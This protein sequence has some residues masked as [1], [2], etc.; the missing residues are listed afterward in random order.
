MVPSP[1][2]RVVAGIDVGGTKK[3][4]QAV[5]LAEGQY[6]EHLASGDAAELAAWCVET[7]RASVIAVDAPCRWSVSGRGRPAEREMMRQGI[8]CFSTPT[9]EVGHRPHPTGYYDWMLKGETVFK[10]LEK[11]HRLCASVSEARQKCCF[12]TFP[13]AIT[14][15]LRGGNANARK[16]RTQRRQ[17]IEQHGIAAKAL[18]NI[19]W[20]DATLCA[21]AAHMAASGQQMVCYG[22]AETGIIIVPA[23]V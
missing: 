2:S 10:E 11:T 6:C 14:W 15:H 22:E 21:L 17:L 4:F 5:A 13:H 1:S 23:Q 19:D 9:S 3:G 12:E 18:T 8:W 20:V 16:K 7:M